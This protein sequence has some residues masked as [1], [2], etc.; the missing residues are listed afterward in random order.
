M[1]RRAFLSGLFGV[2]GAVALGGL[3]M[4]AAQAA[5]IA[6]ALDQP[7]V[8]PETELAEAGRTPD[9]TTVEQA[10]YYGRGRGRRSRRRRSRVVCRT[11]RGR[12]GRLVRTCNR[13]YW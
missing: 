9:G 13:V 10:Q 11:Y 2:A 7:E 8:K 1:N 5:P 3:T 4:H 6:R 12:R